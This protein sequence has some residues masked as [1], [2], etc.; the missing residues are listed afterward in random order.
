[1]YRVAETQIL[2]LVREGLFNERDAQGYPKFYPFVGHS[3]VSTTPIDATLPANQQ[4]AL[5][6]A[7][8]SL[9]LLKNDHDTLPLKSDA[10]LAVV[11]PLSDAR[12]KTSYS[13]GTTP[14]L[15]NA[16][17]TPV[18]GIR[19]AGA[20]SVYTATDGNVIT[21]KS[22]A[23]GRY[24]TQANTATPSVF[25][26]GADRD[27]AAKF[28]SFAWGQEAYGYRSQVNGR[29]LQFAGN[30]INV[31]GTQAFGTKLHHAAVSHPPAAERRRHGFVR[32]R[33]L[34]RVLR[35]RLREPLLHQR[36]LP[37]DRSGDEPA[38]RHRRAHQRRQRQGAEH[39][40]DEVHH[41]DG[42]A[43][44]RAGDDVPDQ[45][46]QRVRGRRRRRAAA[47]QRGRRRRPV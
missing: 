31:G 22:V 18:Q 15:P 17:L 34:H 2:P 40:L 39:G 29:W 32:R 14:T 9:V 11:G 43:R 4:V 10:K 35:R 19:S 41:G 20:T 6:S 27:A 16:G 38:R 3:A 1:M 25:A 42:A 21:L 46:R 36:P 33:D 7:Q 47:Q 44:P 8:E 23:N 26:D 5:Q 30:A 13:V 28:E 37:H 24:L 12:F 45:R